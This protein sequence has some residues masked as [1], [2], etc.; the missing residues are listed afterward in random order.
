MTLHLVPQRWVH[1]AHGKPSSPG[2]NGRR[3][4]GHPLTQTPPAYQDTVASGEAKNSQCRDTL[5][6]ATAAYFTSSSVCI[7]GGMSVRKPGFKLPG[8]K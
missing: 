1:G 4:K 8:K 3:N 6:P 7:S 2:K 5:A